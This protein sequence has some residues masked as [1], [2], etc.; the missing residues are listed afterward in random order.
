MTEKQSDGMKK[1]A[2]FEAAVRELVKEAVRNRY[3]LGSGCVK[4]SGACSLDEH[5][6]IDEVDGWFSADDAEKRTP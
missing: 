2:I 1:A 3:C 5:A 4:C 6:W